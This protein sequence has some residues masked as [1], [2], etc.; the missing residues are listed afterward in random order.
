MRHTH[1]VH[2]LVAS[3]W[4]VQSELWIYNNIILSLIAQA[5]EGSEDLAYIAPLTLVANYDGVRLSIMIFS[6]YRF[7]VDG[8]MVWT[9]RIVH[10]IRC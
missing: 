3:S 5:G 10:Y 9:F 6:S 2:T 1:I 8:D 4:T 7:E